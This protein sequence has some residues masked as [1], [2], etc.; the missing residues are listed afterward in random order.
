MI[1]VYR[2]NIENL[3]ERWLHDPTLKNKDGLTVAM[4]AAYHDNIENL[5]ERWLHDPT[6]KDNQGH[7]VA[8]I[9]RMDGCEIPG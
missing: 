2:D 7:T 9:L 3:P 8:D 6:L 4:I 1:A 5:P